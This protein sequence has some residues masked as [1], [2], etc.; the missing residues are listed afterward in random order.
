MINQYIWS[1]FLSN[2]FLAIIVCF[3]IMNSIA[4]L[5]LFRKNK[6]IFTFVISI[7]NLRFF[8][9]ITNVY[10]VKL[11]GSN[12]DAVRFVRNA[13]QIS[14][15]NLKVDSIVGA[16]LY[17][18]FL[19]F[20]IKYIS[21]NPMYLHLLSNI[22]FLIS[23]Y[24]FMLFADKLKFSLNNTFIGLIILNFLPSIVMNTVTTLREPYQILFLMLYSYFLYKFI[25]SDKIKY[26]ILF[27][28]STILF[29]LTHNGLIIMIPILI[30]IG[31]IMYITTRNLTFKSLAI[32]FISFILFIVIILMMISGVI[33]SQFTESISSGEGLEYAEQYREGSPDSRATYTGSLDT[34]NILTFLISSSILFIKYMTSPLP[35]MMT[36]PIDLISLFENLIRIILLIVVFKNIRDVRGIF[37]KSILV[38][39]FSIEILWAMGTSNWGTAAR[40]H[41]VAFPFP[42]LSFLIIKN[43]LEFKINKYI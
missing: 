4:L 14:T 15:G 22:A 31:A 33:S 38:I 7:I 24:I 32:I 10:I 20:F 28:V 43:E 17:E 35:W 27:T 18:N 16:G 42:I 2:T 21:Y 3:F 34:S 29:G 8:L 41:I 13:F 19:S 30:F 1:A 5:P 23:V 40:H 26:L 39:Y 12:E 25:E 36:S 11:P 9:M 37:S 6:K